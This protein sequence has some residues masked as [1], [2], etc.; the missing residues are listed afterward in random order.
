MNGTQMADEIKK[1][2]RIHWIP[3]VAGFIRKG[4][5]IL[6]GK[7]PPNH[8]LA[9]QWEFPG[10]KIEPGETPEI[11]LVRELNEELGIDAQIGT[12]QLSCAH[13]YGDTH[14][15]ILFFEV[16]YWKGEPKA[17]HH[18]EIEWIKPSELNNRP[19]PDANK[20]I[21]KDIFKILGKS[22]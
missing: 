3:V 21:L 14:I 4:D 5:E 19:I 11:A 17:I 2:K 15:L 12:H 6:V 7:R 10:G 13:S 22:Q 1:T 18:Q 16:R 20:K 8:S 9:G